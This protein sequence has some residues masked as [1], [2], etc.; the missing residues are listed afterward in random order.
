[1]YLRQDSTSTSLTQHT[2]STSITHYTPSTSIT[3]HTPSTSLTHHTVGGLPSQYLQ[4]EQASV[5]DSPQQPSLSHDSTL[6]LPDLSTISSLPSHAPY[7]VATPPSAYL[8]AGFEVTTFVDQSVTTTDTSTEGDKTITTSTSHVISREDHVTSK[9]DHMTSKEDHVTSRK[10][11][12]IPKENHVTS[13][14]DHV[15][16]IDTSAEETV[17][18]SSFSASQPHTPTQ[19]PTPTR[20]SPPSQLHT[21][22]RPSPL[23]TTTKR[24]PVSPT[25]Y[26]MS[27]FS[28][29][30]SY[31]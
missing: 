18:S 10:D 21:P 8:P 19:L 22:T 13:K 12:V 31:L 6:M 24:S 14:E 28:H 26:S 9:G 25:R 15:I 5:T 4:L 23:C 3:Q 2:P 20:S 29:F 27:Y 17:L 16:T 1:M 30:D 7:T 11:H